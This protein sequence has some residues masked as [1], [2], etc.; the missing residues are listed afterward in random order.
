MMM[1]GDYSYENKDVLIKIEN[2]SLSF[3]DT[4][5]LKPTSAEIR[6]IVRPGICQG[7]VI[8]ILGRSGIGKTQFSNILAG[9]QEPTTGKVTVKGGKP[10][11]AGVVGM[12]AQNYPLLMH[13]TILGNLL[14]ALEKSGL[15]KKDREAKAMQSLRDFGLEDK[16][17]FYP[18]QLSGGQ[19]QRVAI[20]QELL[21]S[22]HF[23]VMDE[24]FTG[25]DPLSKDIVCELIAKVSSM[26]E[27]NTIFVVAHDIAALVQIADHLWLFG[28]SY[29]KES[30]DDVKPTPGATIVE[31]YDLIARGLAWKPDIAKSRE[32]TD[33]VNEIKDR[34]GAT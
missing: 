16:A 23:I 32:F 1:D 12:V 10:I 2:V 5:I 9:I 7:Q 22:E 30:G 13:R 21:C 15:S 11:E 3:G 6:D 4:L 27:E 25:L 14:I 34:F 19:R 17:K 31:T 8:G 28:R 29:K 26:H 18:C 33:T 20:A 24:P